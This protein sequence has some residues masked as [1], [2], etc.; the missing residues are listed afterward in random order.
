[1]SALHGASHCAHIPCPFNA[2][3][4]QAL[5][6]NPF[7]P[8]VPCH[9]VIAASLELGGFSGSWGVGCANVVRKRRLLAEEGVQFDDAGRLLPSAA[10][11][12]MPAAELSAA[13]AKAGV[14]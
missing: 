14:L 12:V 4:L 6:R 10:G 7:A 9:R 13:A 11:A 5:R 3:N 8:A 2:P 1:M